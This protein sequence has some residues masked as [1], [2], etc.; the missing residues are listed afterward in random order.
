MRLSLTILALQIFSDSALV[1]KAT[2]LRG[3]EIQNKATEKHEHRKV[4]VVHKSLKLVDMARDPWFYNTLFIHP[5][6]DT[7]YFIFRIFAA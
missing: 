2:L 4:I 3:N 6:T 7:I 1:V 5:K